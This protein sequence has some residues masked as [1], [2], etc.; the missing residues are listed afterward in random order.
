MSKIR[1]KLSKIQFPECCPVCM[2]EAE[3]LVFVTILDRAGNQFDASSWSNG[4]DKT[5]IAL[6]A[7]RGAT[8][9]TI[10][11]CMRHGSKSVR[12]IRT[13]LIGVVGFFVLFYP[14]LFYL[15]QI[16][17]ALIYSRPLIPPLTSVLVLLL[18]LALFFLYG[19]FPRGLERALRFHD[20]SRTKDSLY[21]SI[22]NPEYRSQFLELNE[23]HSEEFQ[24]ET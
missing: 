4:R 21:L 7:A 12:S 19:F 2:Y 5:E 9:F 14:I 23:M 3:D 24:D 15:L 10:P 20:V 17:T 16:N 11:T 6:N 22:S 8:T 18:V 13:K 1:V